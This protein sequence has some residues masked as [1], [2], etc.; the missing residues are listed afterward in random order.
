LR[1]ARDDTEMER[2]GR[3][4]VGLL[5]FLLVCPLAVVAFFAVIVVASWADVEAFCLLDG[6]TSHAAD[7]Y[8]VS[9]LIAIAG[10]GIGVIG[11]MVAYVDRIRWRFVVMPLAWVGA[12]LLAEYLVALAISPQPCQGGFGI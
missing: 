12:I 7:V 4:A 2:S 11:L 5:A 10:T 9:F 8:A 6:P 3:F 1:P